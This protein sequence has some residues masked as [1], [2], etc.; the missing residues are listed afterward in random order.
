MK[1]SNVPPQFMKK[2]A[3]KGGK[4]AKG[5][6]DAMPSGMKNPMMKKKK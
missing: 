6:P 2:D 4:A 3:G 1:K 5:M